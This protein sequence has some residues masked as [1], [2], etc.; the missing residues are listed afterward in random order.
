MQ[1][2]LLLLTCNT[3]LLPYYIV[4]ARQPP[5][6]PVTPSPA[7]PLLAPC[8]HI[9]A[10]LLPC[11]AGAVEL[12]ASH[13]VVLNTVSKPLPFPISASE[14]GQEAREEVRLKHRVLDLRWV[15]RVCGVAVQ[16]GRVGAPVGGAGTGATTTPQAAWRHV[17]RHRTCSLQCS[18]RVWRCRIAVRTRRVVPERSACVR[19]VGPHQTYPTPPLTSRTQTTPHGVQLTPA[20]QAAACDAALPGGRARLH[21][22]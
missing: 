18:N 5:P 2:H 22:G 1:R 7:R 15:V 6:A 3:Q 11:C 13:V 17:P 19:S 16:M 8:T 14:E 21:R 20:P 12:L 4:Q 9:V 10:F